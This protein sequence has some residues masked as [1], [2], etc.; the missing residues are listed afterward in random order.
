ME[1]LGLAVTRPRP[2]FTARL[3][4]RTLFNLL[5]EAHT[6]MGVCTRG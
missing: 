3:G 5:A 4:V 1:R 2:L 6:R